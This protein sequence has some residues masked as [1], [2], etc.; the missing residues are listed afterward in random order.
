MGRA[1]V[2]KGHRVTVIGLYRGDTSIED[3]HGVR[4]LRLPHYNAPK[5][6]YW[7]N[8]LSVRNQLNR[9]H[10]SEPFTLLDAPENGFAFLGR[11]RYGRHVIRMHG[12]HRFL[13][14][15]LGRRPQAIKSWIEKQSFRHADNLCAVSHYV[16]KVTRQ[17]LN[18]DERAIT[19]LYNPVDTQKFRPR[20]DIPAVPGRMLFMGTV[21]ENKGVRQ[22]IQAFRSIAAAVPNA[23]LKIVGRD[24]RD[25]QTGGSFIQSLQ[26]IVPAN[27]QKRIEFLDCIEHSRVPDYLATTEAAVFPSHMEAQGIVTIEAM[28]MGKATIFSRTGP[29]SEV[30]EDGV[31]GLLCDPHDPTSIAECTIR[32]LQDA[33]LRE[34]LGKNAR[35]RVENCFA[36]DR[37]VEQNIE[38]YRRCLG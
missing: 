9:I 27:L 13:A 33:G 25:P 11:A 23:H 15:S 19:V 8:G 26:K 1:L 38:F 7:L 34:Y 14:V 24:G 16:A 31:S 4:V 22:L 36:V 30:I 2:K 29:G 18:L 20:R 5:L 6:N 28:A 12:G 21:N 10:R 17:Q 3:D 32:L 35:T 37:L